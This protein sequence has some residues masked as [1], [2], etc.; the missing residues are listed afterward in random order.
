MFLHDYANAEARASHG[1]NHMQ[2][3]INNLN[4]TRNESVIGDNYQEGIYM[5]KYNE[6]LIKK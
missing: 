5:M 3:I 4:G 6:I 1:A 2:M